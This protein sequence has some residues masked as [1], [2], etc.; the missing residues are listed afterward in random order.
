MVNAAREA[1]REGGPMPRYALLIYDDQTNWQDV[2]PEDQAKVMEEYYDFTDEV[3]KA[4]IA[5][6]SDALAPIDTAKTVRVRSGERMISDGPFAETK[7]QLGGFYIIQ[8]DSE[9][10]ALEWAA[11]VPSART[12]CIEVRPVMEFPPRQELGARGESR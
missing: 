8:C 3:A 9:E 5:G 6:P 7:E 11:K 4:G 12:G 1:A 2:T 10:Q